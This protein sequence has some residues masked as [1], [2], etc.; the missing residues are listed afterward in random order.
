LRDR[1]SFVQFGGAT[2]GTSDL[3]LRAPSLFIFFLSHTPRQH[4]VG[5]GLYGRFLFPNPYVRLCKLLPTC[6]SLVVHPSPLSLVDSP[7]APKSSTPTQFACISLYS[8]FLFTLPPPK[9]TVWSGG[10]PAFTFPCA[11]YSYTVL[12]VRILECFPSGFSLPLTK[13]NPLYPG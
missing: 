9:N 12:P 1:R 5:D 3:G 8:V 13:I 4:T 7:S 2:V 6:T 11:R 10:S